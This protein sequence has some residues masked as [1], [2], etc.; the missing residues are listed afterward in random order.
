MVADIP[1]LIEGAGDGRGLGSQFLRHI[2]RCRLLL[3]IVDLFDHTMPVVDAVAHI[4]QEL[5][6]HHGVDLLQKPRWL[7]FNK[8]DQAVGGQREIEQRI[9]EVVKTLSWQ[10][11]VYA[12]SAIEGRGVK[13]LCQ[14][15]ARFLGSMPSA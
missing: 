15:I 6:A 5:A 8:I 10:G 13:A 12:L 4:Q 14:D 3:H 7:I 2:A 11:K 1:G 9:N